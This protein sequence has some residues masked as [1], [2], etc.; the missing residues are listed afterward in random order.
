MQSQ[1]HPVG[2]LSG[3]LLP[4]GL[5]HDDAEWI[6]VLEDAAL[7]SMCQQMCEFLVALLLFCNLVEPAILFE[8]HNPQMG[9]N[10]IH[11]I[12][13]GGGAEPTDTELGTIVLIAIE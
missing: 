1:R 5:L 10:F 8:R 7:T 12:Q 13:A 11:W 2:H 6:T 3:S 4:P 9:D